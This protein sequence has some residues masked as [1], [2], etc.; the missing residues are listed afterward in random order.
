MVR[1]QFAG[2]KDGLRVWKIAV[3]VLSKHSV[4]AG[5]RW[6]SGLRIRGDADNPSL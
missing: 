3:N 5:K 1:P 6:S 4:M 2:R